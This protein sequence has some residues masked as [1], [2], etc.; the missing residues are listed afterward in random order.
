MDAAISRRT[1]LAVAGSG[2]LAGLSGCLAEGN[3]AET[4]TTLS[5]TDTAT[6][7]TRTPVKNEEVSLGR[8]EYYYFE[9]SLDGPTEVSY[10]VDVVRGDPIH[11][12]LV[13]PEEYEILAEEESGFEAIEGSIVEETYSGT[14]TVSLDSGDYRLIIVNTNA[15]VLPENA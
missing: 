15:D 6:G 5:L 1:L 3:P 10:Q 4:E 9:F 7:E 13:T 8:L 14:A 12:Y 2:A 11:S